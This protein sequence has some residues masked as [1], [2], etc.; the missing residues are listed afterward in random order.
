MT[1][2]GLRYTLFLSSFVHSFVR[3][4]DFDFHLPPFFASIFYACVCVCALYVSTLI[5]KSGFIFRLRNNGDRAQFFLYSLHKILPQN[6]H[7][8]TSA[9]ITVCVCV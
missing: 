7:T 3:L 4:F 2:F 9:R 1:F 8:Y 5:N 6:K